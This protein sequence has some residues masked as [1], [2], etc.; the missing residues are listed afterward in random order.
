MINELL[1]LPVKLAPAVHSQHEVPYVEQGQGDLLLLVH[2]SLCDLR[3]WRWQLS[4]L[5]SSFHVVSLSLPGYWPTEPLYMAYD[6]NVDN[7]CAALADVILA[8]QKPQQ[9]V[10]I[11]GHSRG[12][13]IVAEY[14]TQYPNSLHSIILADPAFTLHQAT[15]P[16][17]ILDQAASLIASGSEAEGL[18]LFIDAVSGPST[19]S[20]M[21]G[22]FKQMVQ[23]NGHTLIAQSRESLPIIGTKHL[24]TLRLFPTLLVGG[25]LSPARYQDSMQQLH[26]SLA[27]S[28]Q[29]KIPKASHGMNLANPK[30]FNQA[31]LNFV[32]HDA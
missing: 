21:V 32:Q 3:Y 30:A 20:R 11:L 15:R 9:K 31:I 28:Q 24:E 22:W 1:Q 8:C 6:F 29:I 26:H 16:L 5:A 18:S 13:H 23:D 19:W 4:K 14:V 2:G 7:H 12:A 27:N 10:H 25:A 17:A